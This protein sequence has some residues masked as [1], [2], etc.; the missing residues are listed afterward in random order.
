[1]STAEELNH[2][3]AAQSALLNDLRKQQA[4]AAAV[5][6]VKKRLGELKRALGQL[7]GGSSK[8]AGKKKERIL[9][10]TPKVRHAVPSL[11]VR[12]AHPR[13][14]AR[15]TTRPQ[16]CTAANTSSAR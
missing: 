1:M 12:C 4:D 10:K 14:R 6:D 3:I 15:A 16:R 9:L 7:A 8:D 2:E 5:E 11:H 13:A